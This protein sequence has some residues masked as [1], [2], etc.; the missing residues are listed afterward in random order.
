LAQSDGNY[1]ED[2]DRNI[3][4]SSNSNDKNHREI[5]ALNDIIDK[6]LQVQQKHVHFTCEDE[7]FQVQEGE[8]DHC[9]E[10]TYVHNQGGYNKG[11]NNYRPNP[12]L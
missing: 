2:Y 10:I 11:Y 4:T 7:L 6:L 5:K 12:N 1:N 8:D 3:C 9:A